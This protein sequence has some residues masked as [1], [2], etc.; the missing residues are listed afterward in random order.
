MLFGNIL[1]KAFMIYSL[2]EFLRGTGGA[3]VFALV[4]L[5]IN[6]Y[7]YHLVKDYNKPPKYK[8]KLGDNHFEVHYED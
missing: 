4:L 1:G 6:W 3:I 5:G 7:I 2:V 8:V